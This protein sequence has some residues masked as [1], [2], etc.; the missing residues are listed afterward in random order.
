M[1]H[2]A[3][4]RRQATLPITF[5]LPGQPDLSLE[6]VLDTGFT[7]YLTLPMAAVTAMR[8]PFLRETGASL[9]DGS[10]VTIDMHTATILWD[11]EERQVSVLATGCRPLLGTAL[12]NDH[13]LYVRFREGGPLTVTAIDDTV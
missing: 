8:L 9:A 4:Q 3:I 12:L 5:R 6:F 11:G 2:G 10:S 7:N 13:D 1:M